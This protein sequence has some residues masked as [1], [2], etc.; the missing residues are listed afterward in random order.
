MVE[1][2]WNNHKCLW[3]GEI[4]ET[5]LK[6]QQIKQAVNIIYE[7]SFSN[8]LKAPKKYYQENFENLFLER[9][10]EFCKERVS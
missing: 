4:K 2:I 5:E 1:A 10:E 9:I 8:N 7:V 6:Q 3:T